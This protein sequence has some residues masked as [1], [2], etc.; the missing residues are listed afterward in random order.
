LEQEPVATDPRVVEAPPRGDPALLEP[1]HEEKASRGTLRRAAHDLVNARQLVR[2]PRP[3]QHVDHHVERQRAHRFE[4]R[5]GATGIPGRDRAAR[6]V[7]DDRTQRAQA[8]AV[9]RR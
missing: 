6:G 8:I 2:V 7:A 5:E 9:E 3:E 4:H 1:A